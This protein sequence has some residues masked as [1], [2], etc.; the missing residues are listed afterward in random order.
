MQVVQKPSVLVVYLC[1]AAGC[2]SAPRWVPYCP[3]C[4][5]AAAAIRPDRR[6]ALA[7][8][9]AVVWVGGGRTG[10][11]SNAWHCSPDGEGPV[12]AVHAVHVPLLHLLVASPVHPRPL[13]RR[14]GR[15]DCVQGRGGPAQA[16][17]AWL[18]RHVGCCRR[19]TTTGDRY[20][21][22]GVAQRKCVL[23]PRRRTRLQARRWRHSRWTAW[24]RLAPR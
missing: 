9:V 7:D 16:L 19:G 23:T 17:H 18:H 15:R 2:I 8:R 13:Q 20:V 3:R 22:C 10:Q 21:P 6:C 24:R 14:A 1:M 5:V 4:A 12:R 11:F